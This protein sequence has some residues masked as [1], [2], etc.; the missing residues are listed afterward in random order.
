MNTAGILTTEKQQVKRPRILTVLC[1]LSL[2]WSGGWVA[3]SLTGIFICKWLAQFTGRSFPALNNLSIKYFY[4]LLILNLILFG[5]SATG[6]I[7]MLRLKKAGYWFYTIPSVLMILVS[8]F[9]V[10]NPVNL[11]YMLVSIVFLILYSVQ[12]RHLG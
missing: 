1:I 12:F 5:S 7:L 6:C 2:S 11:L 8:L 4:V 3:F 9:I 10:L